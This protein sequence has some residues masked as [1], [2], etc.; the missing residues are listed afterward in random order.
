MNEQKEITQAEAV[1]I[2][3]QISE[4][5]IRQSELAIVA[6]E[7]DKLRAEKLSAVRVVQRVH[8]GFR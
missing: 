2:C 5:F 1:R 4:R 6:A 7:T 3:R 8:L